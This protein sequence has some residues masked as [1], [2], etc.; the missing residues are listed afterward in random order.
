MK[1]II[2]HIAD[3]K[4]PA[5]LNDTVAAKDFETRLPFHTAGYDSGIDYCCT[6]EEGK[7]D[8]NERQAGWKNGDINLAG[9]W[10]ALLYAGE[11]ESKA[12]EDLMII[13]RLKDVNDLKGL[14][15]A[16]EITVTAAD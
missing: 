4:I 2:L 10:F 7:S 5:V 9:G 3:R 1:D 16:V 6:A 13:G 8:P 12:Y 15:K 14:P 11:E